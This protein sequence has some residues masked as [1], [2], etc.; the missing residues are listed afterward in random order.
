MD[1]TQKKKGQLSLGPMTIVVSIAFALFFIGVLV[2]AFALAGGEM[3][4]SQQTGN[5][6][7]DGANLAID[8][9]NSTVQGTLGYANFSPTLWVMLGISA[10]L[11]I[12]IVGVGAFFLARR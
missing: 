10:L 6:T 3:I 1:L 2:F 8:V 11:I 7:I 9:I 4:S 5:S 12:L